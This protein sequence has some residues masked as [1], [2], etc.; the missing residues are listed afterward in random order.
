MAALT[1]ALAAPAV[2]LSSS[3]TGIAT[4]DVV[5]L[6]LAHACAWFAAAS[7]DAKGTPHVHPD[8]HRSRMAVRRCL[9]SWFL[10]IDPCTCTACAGSAAHCARIRWPRIAWVL[11][12][13]PQP[14][15]PPSADA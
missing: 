8:E 7:P 13:G 3:A 9:E 2:G 4:A 6:R 12:L 11:D 10:L 14:P 15:P 5:L 1:V